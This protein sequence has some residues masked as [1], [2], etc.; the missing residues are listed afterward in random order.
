MLS[1]LIPI[2]NF[3]VQKLV[4]TLHQQ[5]S[6][7][8]ILFEIVCLDDGSQDYFKAANKQILA[9]SNVR[10][11][12]AK[13]NMGRSKIRNELS[14]L[15]VYDY[16]LYMDCDSMPINEHY[17]QNYITHL[18]PNSLLYGGRVYAAKAPLEK[19]LYFHWYYG[20]AREVTSATLRA[21]FP[22]QS[23]MTNNFLIPKAIFQQI[24]FDEQLTQ[25]GHEDTLFGIELK[26]RGISILHLNN[27]LEHIGLETAAVFVEK[28]QKAIQNLYAL[29]LTY[30][31]GQDIKLLRVYQKLKTWKLHYLFWLGYKLFAGILIR[32][33]RSKRPILKAFD[34]YKLGYL[35]DWSFKRE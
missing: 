14:K 30:D 2:Y 33:I 15:A 6:L 9:H 25:Y 20:T 16:L 32:N 29:Q 8:N 10:Y 4:Q 1:I 5:A 26:K 11:I 17:I 21:N 19:D 34:L 22:Y 13:E 23:F 35:I 18:N 27:P 24:Y 3:D 31:L 12:E 7:S 28:T